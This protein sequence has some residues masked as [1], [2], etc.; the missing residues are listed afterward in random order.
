MATVFMIVAIPRIMTA[1]VSI[2]APLL[3]VAVRAPA[4]CLGVGL[5]GV[6][7]LG[8]PGGLATGRVALYGRFKLSPEGRRKLIVAVPCAPS[9]VSDRCHVHSVIIPIIVYRCPVD[10]RSVEPIDYHDPTTEVGDNPFSQCRPY[11][12]AFGRWQV[13]RRNIVADCNL[14]AHFT[15]ATALEGE[16]HYRIR[17][18][19]G[20]AAFLAA[21]V[22]V[23]HINYLPARSGVRRCRSI[24]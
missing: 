15:R 24:R 8:A 11:L 18:L 14:V 23:E 20:P 2:S 6:V 9:C 10:D 19:G 13:L 17:L 4:R 5:H 22:T 3:A 16:S 7:T 1:V 21:R 12:L